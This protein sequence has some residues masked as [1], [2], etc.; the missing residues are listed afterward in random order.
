MD[1]NILLLGGT[2]AMGLALENLMSGGHYEV[3]ITS[4]SEHK[5][6]DNIHYVE[7]NGLDYNAVSE[8]VNVNFLVN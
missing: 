2:G 7:L 4:R 3:Y 6:Y 1:N 5:S 8:Y